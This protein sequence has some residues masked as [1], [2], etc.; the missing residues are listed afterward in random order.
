MLRRGEGRAALD[1][2]EK[3]RLADVLG[4]VGVAEIGVAQAEDEVGVGVHQPL[5][6]LAGQAR[7][8][9]ITSFRGPSIWN[10][11]QRPETIHFFSKKFA[12]QEKNR[13]FCESRTPGGGC[14]GE[15]V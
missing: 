15:T 12:E 3:D 13:A 1:Q 14:A 6:L 2:L 10:T 7:G 9:G 11:I 8:H 5:R 4:V